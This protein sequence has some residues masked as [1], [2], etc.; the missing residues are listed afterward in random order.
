MHKKRFCPDAPSAL[1]DLNALRV[2]DGSGLYASQG[3]LFKDGIFGRD[4]L[5][6]AEDLLEYKPELVRSVI[7]TLSTL[8]GRRYDE[9]SAEAP[10]AIHHEYRR[11]YE[12][13]SEISRGIL[14]RLLERRG[15]P[16]QSAERELRDYGSVDATPL[17]IRLVTQYAERHGDDFLSQTVT[18]YTGERA[19]MGEC[20]EDACAF[21]D[22]QID[23]SDIGLYEQQPNMTR[24]HAFSA[25]KDSSSHYLHPDATVV[26]F[27][28]PIAFVEVQGLAYDALCGAETVL[29][30]RD[31]V[32]ADHFAHQAR[33]L[34]TETLERFWM[35]DSGS[36]GYFAAAIDRD[37][38]AR[39][40]KLRTVSSSGALLLDT[41]LFD[42]LPQ[43]QRETY[44]KGIISTIMSDRFLTEVGVRCRSL[45]YD[46]LLDFDDYHGSRA[47]WAKETFDIAKGLRRQG[48]LKLA[49]ELENRL[50]NAVNVSGNHYEFFFVSPQG[51]VHYDVG[52]QYLEGTRT[53]IV[54]TNIPE[55]GQAWTVSALYAI[56]RLRDAQWRQDMHHADSEA[57][58]QRE[59]EARVLQTIPRAKLLMSK[60]ARSDKFTASKAFH[61][62]RA[63]GKGRDRA[64]RKR[65]GL[66]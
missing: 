16:D 31:P 51:D 44:L 6:A 37:S 17:Y 43:E 62:E 42:G 28:Q 30:S 41:C 21:L 13:M 34:Q 56:K 50:L 12:G 60:M 55:G 18:R 23:I 19:T 20:F 63:I 39:P 36:A 3:E 66:I 54:T 2:P 24:S 1:H 33:C 27:T 5:E 53:P 61:I 10:G 32:R 58:W 11:Y 14:D 38:Q 26:D 46:Q 47:V 8:Q 65:M 49:A 7:S 48:F 29:Q 25:W 22:H 35:P 45:E 57:I 15:D 64:F 40:R 9:R 52:E 4:S 59:F